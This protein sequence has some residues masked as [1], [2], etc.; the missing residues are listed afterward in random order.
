[1]AEETSI[2][3]ESSQKTAEDVEDRKRSQ[4]IA[5]NC[6]VLRKDRRKIV[7]DRRRPQKTAKERKTNK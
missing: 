1:M 4:K 6:R 3:S 5:E 2:D 7:Q